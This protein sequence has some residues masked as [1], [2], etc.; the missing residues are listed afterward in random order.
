MNA[1]KKGKAE[2]LKEFGIDNVKTDFKYGQIHQTKVFD[3]L[4]SSP[5]PATLFPYFG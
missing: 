2:K 3:V 5:N 1:I 4:V